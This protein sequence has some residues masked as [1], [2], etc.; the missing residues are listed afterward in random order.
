MEDQE[1]VLTEI[2]KLYNTDQYYRAAIYAYYKTLLTVQ[3][4]GLWNEFIF[5]Q[6]KL[7]N[8]FK[9]KC[10]TANILPI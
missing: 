1:I 9:D 10:E 7:L 5:E 4:N 3:E 8:K 6:I 2:I